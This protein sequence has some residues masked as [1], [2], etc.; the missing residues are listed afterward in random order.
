[1]N[2]I[3]PAKCLLDTNTPLSDTQT[4]DGAELVDVASF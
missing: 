1:M 3:L 2:G 4:T